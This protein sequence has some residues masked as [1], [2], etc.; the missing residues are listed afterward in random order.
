MKSIL[1]ATP[2]S[3]WSNEL[4]STMSS[5]G[6]ICEYSA[7]EKETQLKISQKEYF[8]IVMDIDTSKHSCFDVLKFI[9]LNHHSGLVLIYFP[10]K[11][12]FTALQI[13]ESVLTKMGVDKVFIGKASL[14]TIQKYFVDMDPTKW[15]NII[16]FDP[17]SP[18]ASRTSIDV[19]DAKMTRIKLKELLDGSMAIFDHYLRIGANRYV[20]ILNQ[21]ESFQ[22]E[23]FKKYAIDGVE[24]IYFFTTDR[25]VYINYMNGV[26]ERLVKGTT[27]E[28]ATKI[29]SSITTKL[30]EEIYTTGLRPQLIEEGVNQCNSIQQIVKKEPGLDK[31][32]D[33]YK[34]LDPAAYSHLYLVS[35]FSSVICQ[36]LEWAG[37]KTKE[38]I[39]LGALLHDIGLL[40]LP[41][42]VRE[43]RPETM[44]PKEL[45]L[46][47]LHPQY[48]YE[49]LLETNGISQQVKQIV[50]QH[51][52][53]SDGTGFPN[54]L[55]NLKI[56]PLAKIVILADSFADL[57]MAK[58]IAPLAGLKDL[59]N[60]R[61]KLVHY[62]A[63]I[64]R[65][66]VSGF[67]PKGNS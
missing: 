44:T 61:E 21:G 31:L 16:A 64:I 9:K 49:I 2:D 18:T 46:Y 38:S 20:K 40:K 42:A 66:L 60:D 10:S 62:D 47:K 67:M 12:K 14:Q 28:K 43:K 59:L 23:P 4:R 35:F 33:E 27:P 50:Y 17:A 48:G 11:E 65:S 19:E 41:A 52:E 1:I 32:L 24:F 37:L 54:K 30:V 39:G 25:T 53:F 45:E 55:S 15:K 63:T 36:N 6:F 29:V 51:H 3:S 26:A 34:E 58:R 5:S 22:S 57:L 7:S 13:T 8:A 56:Y